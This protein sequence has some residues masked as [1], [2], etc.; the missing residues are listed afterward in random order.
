M[1]RPR[2]S[3]QIARGRVERRGECVY[4]A[5]LA[6]LRPRSPLSLVEW[7]RRHRRI[8]TGPAVVGPGDDVRWTP[9]L[10]PPQAAVLDA[11]D[12]PRWSRVVL[13]TSPQTFG[14]TDIAVSFALSRVHQHQQSGIYVA[15]RAELAYQQWRRRFLPAIEADPELAGLLI[16]SRDDAGGKG[17]RYFANGAAM[18][19]AGAESVGALSGVSC[20]WMI[21]DDVQAMSPLPGF[22]HPVDVVSHRTRAMR[23][24]QAKELVIG[25]AGVVGDYLDREYRAST[26]YMPFVR[27]PRCRWYQVLDAE[28]LEYA[29]SS[30]A[31]A[32]R[33]A[34]LRCGNVRC[35]QEFV[36]ADL[37]R[38]LDDLHWLS[39]PPNEDWLHMPPETG[40]VLPF[41]LPSGWREYPDSSRE[42]LACGF[43]ASALYWPWQRWGNVAARLL[44]ARGNPDKQRDAQQHVAVRPWQE[45]P[46]NAPGVLRPDEVEAHAGG[47][48]RGIVP[49]D[50]DIV[51]LTVDVQH[52]YVYWLARGWNRATGTSWLIDLGSTKERHERS[53]LPGGLEVVGKL[54]AEGWPRAD[55]ERIVP[56]ACLIDSHY[57]P[58]VV[59][60]HCV[61]YGLRRWLPVEGTREARRIW[62]DA[63]RRMKGG[64][65][66]YPICVGEAKSVLS[67]LLAVPPGQPGYMHIPS[68]LP[69]QTLSAYSRHMT[70]EVW[71]EERRLWVK[72]KDV[73]RG[74]GVLLGG[75]ARRNDWWDC[76]VYQVAGAVRCGVRLFDTARPVAA[77]VSGY[78]VAEDVASWRI[79]REP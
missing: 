52:D 70:S 78:R 2:L 31:A 55:G 9:R 19:F 1:G 26:A 44:A 58:D 75:S 64:R 62:P 49:A 66:Y 33:T 29:D 25:T 79:G 16:D 76:E 46:E 57:L 77:V 36:D 50:A 15:S 68:D 69:S 34:R 35:G 4:D 40:R 43:W 22:G 60:Q 3:D 28:R 23:E 61:R 67:R 72:R 13:L 7:A 51:L 39:P 18:Y 41:E 73:G 8:T 38:L 10:F 47:Y 42:S 27:C 63:P 14:K 6:A 32:R 21:C 11:L 59:W 45:S 17:C 56:T 65:H 71:D 48:S 30:A 74:P 12:D 54:A 24:A 53:G 37:P 20:A 5:V